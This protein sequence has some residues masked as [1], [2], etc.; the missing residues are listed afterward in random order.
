MTSMA[1]DSSHDEF[2][3]R[4]YVGHRGEVSVIEET[5]RLFTRWLLNTEKEDF[6]THSTFGLLHYISLAIVA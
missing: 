4:Y 6:F 3:V 1:E 5:S 2:Y